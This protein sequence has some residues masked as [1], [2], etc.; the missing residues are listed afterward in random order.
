MAVAQN[1]C[2][3]RVLCRLIEH[4]LSDANTTALVN[5][6]LSKTLVLSR[7]AFGHFVIQ[8]ILEQGTEE[9]RKRIS[10]SLLHNSIVQE[11]QSRSVRYVVESALEFCM[12]DRQVMINQLIGHPGNV[13]M[14]AMNPNGC[15]I[16]QAILRIAG[17]HVQ[18]LLSVLAGA[19]EQLRGSKNGRR[20][21]DEISSS[22]RG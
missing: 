15:H 11:A 6:V 2:G 7:H 1:K 14:L 10:Q 16:V 19:S 22:R 5:E 8:C 12:E 13:V 3:C 17:S 4:T 9:Q 21:L 20:L 18:Q